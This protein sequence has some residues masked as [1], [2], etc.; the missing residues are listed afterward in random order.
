MLGQT[1]EAKQRKD[2]GPSKAGPIDEEDFYRA[3]GDEVR[4]N[5]RAFSEYLR[6]GGYDIIADRQP[7]GTRRLHYV[8]PSSGVS[9]FTLATDYGGWVGFG[10]IPGQYLDELRRRLHVLMPNR[11][12][13][14]DA[15]KTSA[16]VPFALFTDPTFAREV[17]DLVM[18]MRSIVL[19]GE[20]PE[21]EPFLESDSSTGLPK[22]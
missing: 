20:E 2:T 17:A 8:L 7:A 1:E 16:G 18:W 11:Q 5:L 15:A 13:Q 10:S 3:L 4:A 19:A 6:D 12:R 9:T 21:D 14:I 22:E